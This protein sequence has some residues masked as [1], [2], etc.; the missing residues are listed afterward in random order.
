MPAFDFNKVVKIWFSKPDQH[1][2][3]GPFNEYRLVSHRLRFPNDEI[4]LI[5]NFEELSSE[6]QNQ[7]KAFCNKPPFDK[8]PI[9]LVSI[10]D[11]ERRAQNIKKTPH[12]R[13]RKVQLELLKIASLERTLGDGCLAAAS[14][15]ARTLSGVAGNPYTDLD[16]T[17][18][19]FVNMAPIGSTQPMFKEFKGDTLNLDAS[20]GLLVNAT[21]EY[22]AER[23]GV[24][25]TNVSNDMMACDESKTDFL[26]YYRKLILNRYNNINDAIRELHHNK[27]FEGQEL[28]LALKSMKEHEKTEENIPTAIR[29]RRALKRVCTPDRYE[30]V[31]KAFILETAGP[32]CMHDAIIQFIEKEFIPTCKTKKLYAQEMVDAFK[33]LGNLYPFKNENDMLW[34]NSKN[35][36]LAEKWTGFEENVV[37]IQSV[38]RMFKAKKEL[39]K[40]KVEAVNNASSLYYE[41]LRETDEVVLANALGKLNSAIN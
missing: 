8:K 15:I 6:K 41:A 12:I 35:N 22:D 18:L 20:F 27:V 3:G 38:F 30:I 39:K 4:T 37:K 16:R 29:F 21:F 33:L 14:D 34:L 23:G 32:G 13:D 31:F 24:E 36:V 9:N 17:K 2:L 25:V 7:L 11:V 5:S 40:L 26:V 28:S 1:P 10:H 19:K